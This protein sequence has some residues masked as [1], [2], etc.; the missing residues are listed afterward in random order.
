MHGPTDIRSFAE[1]LQKVCRVRV[2]GDGCTLSRHHAF[3]LLWTKR[4]Y[5]FR[6][7]ELS[8]IAERKLFDAGGVER[9]KDPDGVVERRGT[10]EDNIRIGI[11]DR[12]S[13][14]DGIGERRCPH[15]V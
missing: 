11:S 15:P 5:E 14:R 4:V 1:A 8:A 12:Q 10:E 13:D 2:F 9:A 7:E 3:G 6:G